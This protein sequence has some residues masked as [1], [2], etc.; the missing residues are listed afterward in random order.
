MTFAILVGLGNL[1]H[2]KCIKYEYEILLERG[3]QVKRPDFTIKAPKR[4]YYWEHLG[5]LTD[6]GY[7]K[8]WKKKEAWYLDQGI[9]TRSDKDRLVVTRDNP[10]GSLDSAEIEHVISGLE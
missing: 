1:L 9:T 2:S 8:D 7:A 10:D 6:P 4:T 3:G 5:M